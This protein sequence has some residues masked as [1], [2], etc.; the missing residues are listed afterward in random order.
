M[1]E[2]WFGNDKADYWA[3]DTLDSTGKA[4]DLHVASLVDVLRQLKAITAFI[5]GKVHA[6]I[7]K[8]PRAKTGNE[9]QP[10]AGSNLMHPSFVW[11]KNRWVCR[12]CGCFKKDRNGNRIGRW[13]R[14]L[15]G[16][17]AF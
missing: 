7:F 9:G 17:T 6:N 5:G 1:H 2:H 3:K 10:K 13:S 12:Q 4:G 16:G 15:E 11:Y 14:I 8:V